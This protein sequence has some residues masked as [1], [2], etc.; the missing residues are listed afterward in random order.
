MPENETTIDRPALAWFLLL[1]GGL[2]L[3]AALALLPGVAD[4]VR[5]HLPVPSTKVLRTILLLAIVVHLGEGAIAWVLASKRG[6][7]ARRW[8]TQ[9]AI[10]GF[11]SLRLLASHQA[12]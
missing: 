8:A 9:T 11:P 12:V 5:S 1:D 3:L 7:D 4:R 2:V 6:L 10:V